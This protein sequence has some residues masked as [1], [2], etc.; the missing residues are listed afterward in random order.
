M[1]LIEV[2]VAVDGRGGMALGAARDADEFWAGVDDTS[3][4]Q[5]PDEPLEVVLL[6][7]RSGDGDL[8]DV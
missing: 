2:W 5:R 6:T 8:R 1:R 3:E 4:L 7:E